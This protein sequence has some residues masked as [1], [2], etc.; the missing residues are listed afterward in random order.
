[1]ELDQK[2]QI[3]YKE[4]LIYSFFKVKK[5]LL[6]LDLEF[7][8]YPIGQTAYNICSKLIPDE[9]IESIKKIK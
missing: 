5:L 9:A 1:M 8:K 4:L 3:L 7:E 2:L 6:N